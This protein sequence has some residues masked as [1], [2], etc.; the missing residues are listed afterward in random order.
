MKIVVKANSTN[1]QIFDS[2]CFI[3]ILYRDTGRYYYSR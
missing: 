2:I 3:S 1:M